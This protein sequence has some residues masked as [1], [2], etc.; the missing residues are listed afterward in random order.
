MIS[1]TCSSDVGNKKYSFNFWVETLW[2]AGTWKSDCFCKIQ[3]HLT[4]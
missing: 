1:G 3:L 2:K 4:L